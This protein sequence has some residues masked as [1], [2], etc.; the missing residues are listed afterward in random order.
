MEK[1]NG[2]YSSEIALCANIL[3]LV[4]DR[5]TDTGKN[6]FTPDEIDGYFGVISLVIDRLNELSDKTGKEQ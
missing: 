3:G 4:Q 1:D 6:V 5:F 2:Y